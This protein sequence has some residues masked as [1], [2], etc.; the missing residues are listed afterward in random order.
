MPSF[1][2]PV[3][4]WAVG[5]IGIPLLIHLIRRRKLKVVRWAA[6][7]FLRQS[8]KK[9]RRRLRIEELILLALRMLIVALAALAFARPVLHALGIPFLLR[10]QPVY[11][12]IVLDN[13]YSMDYR[14]AG[15]GRT[16]W[17]RAKTAVD[18][19]LTHVL[20]D[21]DSASLILLSDR[22]EESVGE[23]SFDLKLVRQRAQAA[24]VS[25]RAT[26]YQSAA[27]LVEK[28]LKASKASVKEV[29]WLTDDQAGA[30]ETSRRESGHALWQSI[31]AQARVTWVSVGPAP[32]DRENISVELQPLSRELVTP[33]LPARIEA[34]IANDGV[35]PR[36][37]LLVNLIVDEKPAGSQRVSI[38]PNG[39]T[40]VLFNPLFSQPG[41]HTG[42]IEL[43]SPQTAD[44]LARDNRALF[45]VR[46]RERIK[47][48]VQDMR[49]TAD[50]SKSE[51]FYLMTAMAPGGEAESLA[52][53]LR[54]GEGLGNAN[55]RGYDAVV[56]TGLTGLSSGDRTALAEYVRGGGGLLIFP[57][58][59]TDARRV[60]ADLSAAGLLPAQ[61]GERRVLTDE[62][63]ITL[64][65]A[66]ITHPVLSIFK[67]TSAMN[68]GTARFTTYYPLEPATDDPNPNAVL[69]MIRFSNGDPAFV[70]RHV[71]LGNV[72][73]GASSA[74]TV[75][76]QL[77]LKPSFVP[78]VYQLLS[79]L[80]QGPSSRRNLRQNE[81][82]LLSLP[83]TDANRPVRVVGPDNRA[84]TQ[85]SVLDA[86]GV[87]FTYGSTDRAGLY[88]ISIPGTN[89][90][91]AFAVGLPVGESNLAFA[92]PED[93]V[94]GAGLPANRLTVA[95][96]PTQIQASVQ[97][98]RYGV[99]VWRY[100]I[101]AVIGLMFV[102][103]FLAQHWGRRG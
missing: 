50:P 38:S 72:V 30:W 21:G 37:D 15:D 68:L 78:L 59:D 95:G 22:P 74:G 17:E 100:L 29:Y 40:T 25:D 12:V 77:P 80:G 42:R 96:S 91:D 65:P 19:I 36:S 18:E 13:S 20:K 86:R 61:L 47:V 24:G 49:P 82:L 51:S 54:E 87:T 97:R 73:L 70:E 57:G 1:L 76:N 64:N 28:R 53:R 44:G 83:L 84:T 39:A 85:N 90:T 14:S 71:G 102:E 52:P 4:L 55:L 79:Y 3:F 99:E 66:T 16:S 45:V 103:S 2:N 93:A 98:S 31:G 48:M 75:W 6:M 94:V 63:A 5:L 7:E 67:D 92:P 88:R 81:P 62:T 43:A 41:T 26:D 8:Q 69:V 27:R 56:L 32:N 46:A 101:V 35:K 60:N 9:Q 10:S 33:H 11:A 89:M 34:R 58:P 23:P